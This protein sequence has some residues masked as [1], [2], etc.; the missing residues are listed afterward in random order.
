MGRMRWSRLAP[1]LLAAAAFAALAWSVTP[2]AGAS[3][4]PWVPPT[5]PADSLARAASGRI[6]AQSIGSTLGRIAGRRVASGVA[7]FRLDAVLD[8]GGTLRARRLSSGN[9]ATGT[10]RRLDLAPESF[11]SGPFGEVVVAGTDDGRQS[12]LRIV[13]PVAGCAF[14][15]GT[16]VDVI[17]SAIVTLDGAALVEHRVDRRTRADLGIWRRTIGDAAAERIL[18]PLAPDAA[19]GP[20]FTTELAWGTD[21]RLVVM[22]CGEIVCRARVAELATHD[23]IEVDGIGPLVGL[24]DDRLIVQRACGGLP[25][26]VEAIDLSTGERQ[27]LAATAGLSTLA[28]HSHD[29]LVS[30]TVDGTRLTSAPIGGGLV[31]ELGHLPAGYDLALSAHQ[32][33]SGIVRPDG[34]IVAVPGGRVPDDV[35]RGRVRFVD[36]LTGRPAAIAEVSQ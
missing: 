31:T 32:A 3:D 21:G 27:I 1:P 28:G 36:A 12:R 9:A 26:P 34:W 25:C 8:A 18:P 17:R 19:T 14:D 7:W 30:E 4:G 15:T 2:T 22:S 33:S 29:R 13:D 10:V 5:C 24:V 20:T 16:S 6:A 23:I 35:G 11:T